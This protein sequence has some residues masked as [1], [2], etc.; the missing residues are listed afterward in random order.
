MGCFL[1][2]RKFFRKTIDS[3]DR[4]GIMRVISGTSAGDGMFRRFFEKMAYGLSRFMYGRYGSDK[5]NTFLMVLAVIFSIAGMILSRF[6]VAACRIVSLCLTALAYVTLGFFIFRSLSRNLTKRRKENRTFLNMTAFL[7]DRQ[8]RYY[9]C[10]KCKQT[11][12]VPRGRGKICIKCPKCS[13][14]FIKKT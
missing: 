12:R 8:N 6:N 13:E 3:T 5:L 14:K 1:T 2:I 11:V 7:W 4:F 9:H 10:P